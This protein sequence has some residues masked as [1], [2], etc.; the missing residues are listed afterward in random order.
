MQT[1]GTSNPPQLRSFARLTY[2]DTSCTRTLVGHPTKNL[3]HIVQI[4]S[5][6][7]FA[8]Q[9]VI[10]TRRKSLI[11]AILL[12]KHNVGRTTLMRRFRRQTVSIREAH[13]QK[14]QLLNNEQ[15]EVL[16]ECTLKLSARGFYLT[17]KMLQNLAQEI[18]KHPVSERRSRH[19]RKHHENQLSSVYMRN[20]L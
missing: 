3:I 16:I 15:E 2:P 7:Q 12:E 4:L 20:I 1:Y 17:F 14:L 11:L 19:F 18:V 10:S 6:Y 8:L 13:S 5:K 9:S